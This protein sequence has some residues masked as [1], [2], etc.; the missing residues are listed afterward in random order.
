MVGVEEEQEVSPKGGG[1]GELCEPTMAVHLV[2]KP[3]TAGST[4]LL[5]ESL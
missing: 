3:A 4:D 5:T 2:T 1:R